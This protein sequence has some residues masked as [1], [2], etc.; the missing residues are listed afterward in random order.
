VDTSKAS[1]P[2]VLVVEDEWLTRESIV[3]YLRSHGCTVFE[4]ASGEEAL[5]FLNGKRR[6]LDVLFTD[7]RLGGELNG[8]D[9]AEEFRQHQ[10]EIR[11]LYTSGYSIQPA[12][13]VVGSSFFDKPY[14]PKEILQACLKAD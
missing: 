10:P 3:D 8:W 5:T 9:I 13:N 4:A 12:R 14:V 7:I 2:V 6:P 11:I 1:V